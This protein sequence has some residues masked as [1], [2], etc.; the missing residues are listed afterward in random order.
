MADNY[1]VR[2]LELF[3]GFGD[4]EALVGGGRRLSYSDLREAVI[5]LAHSLRDNGIRPD[6]TVAVVLGLTPD[7][8]IVHLALHLLGCR[9]TWLRTGLT[10]RELDG[11][12][13]LT[14]PQ[15]LIYDPRADSSLGQQLAGRLGAAVLCLG[16]GGLGPDLLAYTGSVFDPN[17][18]GPDPDVVFQTSGTTGNPKLIHHSQEFY[19]QIHR[20]AK[21][22]VASDEPVWRHLSLSVFGHVS[23]Q[24]SALLYLFTGGTL[25]LMPDYDP[26][27]LLETIARERINSTF[28]APPDLYDILAHP[29]LAHTDLS[30]MHMLSVGAAPAAP[31]RLLEAVRR[32]GPVVRITYGLSE[33]PFISANPALTDDPADRTR[34]GSAGRPY[35]DVRVQIRAEDGETEVPTGEVGELWVHSKLN[36][37]GYPGAPDLTAETLIDGWVRTRDLGYRDSLG[38]LYLVG[39]TQDQITTGQNCEKVFPRP[40]EDALASHPQI[41]A[42]AVI[43]VPHPTMV[44]AIHAYVIPIPHATVTPEDL[45]TLVTTELTEA[46]SPHTIE[47]VTQLPTNPTGKI[48]RNALRHHYAISHS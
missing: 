2:A 29:A 35:G 42:A 17:L 46:W 20:L 4:H 44:E 18:V 11:Y 15:A 37:T 7:V 21:A 47:F 6:M 38:Y 27:E 36:F 41:R 28:I 45:T 14:T 9:T 23:G 39:R 34:L 5:D 32:F 26:A 25:F 48:D 33:S 40:I 1:V 10:R 12:L 3:A 19:W 22:I 43:G 13:E 24:I 16:P 30:S 8:P 31:A